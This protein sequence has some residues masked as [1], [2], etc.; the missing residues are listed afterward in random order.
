MKLIDFIS[1][2][3]YLDYCVIWGNK[4]EPEYVGCVMNIPW[5]LIRY[6]IG[7]NDT[8]EKSNCYISSD[9]GEVCHN[10]VGIVINLIMED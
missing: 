5:Y 1:Q 8:S 7:R 4:D 9:L 6:E 10:N 2:L 3:D